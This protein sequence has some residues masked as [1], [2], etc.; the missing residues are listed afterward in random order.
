MTF[1][2][3]NILAGL[4]VS[5][6]LGLASLGT[7]SC[8]KDFIDL[9]DPT[10]LLSSEGY[11]DSLSIV[12]GVTAAYSALQDQYGKSS[13]NNRGIFVFGEIPSDNSTALTSGERLNEFD[14][15]SIISDNPRLQS[16]WLM[17]YRTI[18]RCNIILSRGQTV[19][20]TAANR[21]RYFGEVRF[22]RALSYFNAVRIWGD[23]PLVT[24]EIESIPDAYQF[25]RTPQAQVYTQI[26]EDLRFAKKWLPTTRTGND[27]GRVTKGAAQGMLGKV[28]L[29]QKQYAPAATELDSV[30]RDNRFSLQP[31]FANI[32]AT[33]NEMNSEIL[34]AVRYT[35]GALGL[36]SAFTT[37]FM[38]GYNETQTRSIIGANFTGQQFNVVDSDLITTANASGTADVRTA[39]SFVLPAGASATTSYYT[40][41][42]IDTPTSSTDAENDWIV[43]RYA[44]VL[45]M[46]AEAVN[47]QTGPNAAAL[48]AVNQV[49]RRSR[50]LPTNTANAT[51]DL[52]G[53]ISST[54]LRTRL[55]LER[56]LELNFEGHRWFDLVRTD[57]AIA[58]MNAYFARKNAT[59]RINQ[60][61]LLFPIPV[62]EIQ[63]NPIL[64][65]NP[66]YN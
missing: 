61:N 38:P 33:S 49:I 27:L 16:Q 28:F 32:F 4:S 13:A 35:K 2:Y 5:A 62:Q 36:G 64:T 24:G 50:N 40:R 6:L 54:D 20:L 45:L 42:Y 17:T 41:K 15:F 22:I 63:T 55:E 7:T 18:A 21:N 9:D 56:R 37:W 44:D 12:S 26:I 1:N 23:V 59:T 34:F 3:K 52:P 14:D 58:V 31:V 43:L 30:I 47:E 11:P 19:K 29:T 10:R 39:A 48:S 51:V 8:S 57:R 66:G 60:N 25:G 46:Y 65:Q 53:S